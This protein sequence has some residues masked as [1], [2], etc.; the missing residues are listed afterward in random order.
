MVR[1]KKEREEGEGTLGCR[2]W[3]AFPNGR[4]AQLSI[5]RTQGTPSSWALLDHFLKLLWKGPPVPGRIFSWVCL[6]PLLPPYVKSQ[7]VSIE[8]NKTMGEELWDFCRKEN[9]GK[10]TPTLLLHHDVLVIK[11]S[12]TFKNISAWVCISYPSP[13]LSTFSLTHHLTWS[14]PLRMKWR[15][16]GEL[17]PWHRWSLTISCWF[18]FF[19]LYYSNNL[20]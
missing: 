9:P 18:L 2:T 12:A 20:E 17:G 13:V 19:L 6:H 16:G 10:A 4:I 1:T 7:G 11:D 15:V 3:E 5:G 8:A 14:C